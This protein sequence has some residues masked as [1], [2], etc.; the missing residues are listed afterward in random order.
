MDFVGEK[1]IGVVD[2]DLRR[3]CS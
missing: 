2:F 3:F 1:I